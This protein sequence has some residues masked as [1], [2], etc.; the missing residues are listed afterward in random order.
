MIGVL[1]WAGD[2]ARNTRSRNATPRMV[3]HGDEFVLFENCLG[4]EG[5]CTGHD[6]PKWFELGDGKRTLSDHVTLAAKYVGWP[7]LSRDLA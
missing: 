7:S 6:C 5:H 3:K 1:L 2:R 4:T